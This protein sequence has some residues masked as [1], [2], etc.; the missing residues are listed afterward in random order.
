MFSSNEARSKNSKAKL[1]YYA[2]DVGILDR[3]KKSNRM[4]RFYKTDEGKIHKRMCCIKQSDTMKT[5]IRNGEFTPPITNTWTHWNAQIVQDNIIKKFRSSWEAC[6]WFCNQHLEYE[7]IRIKGNL[8]TYISDFYDSTTNTLYEIKPC[9]RY[10]IEIDKMNT[11]INYCIT[12][13]INFIWINENNIEN[14]IDKTKIY[15]NASAIEQ[16]NKLTKIYD[17]KTKN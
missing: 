12:N 14:Y 9:S 11:I 8:K 15:T 16:Y 5:K 2:T 4:K 10:N 17:Y 7:T 3:E 13:N 1:A 6:F